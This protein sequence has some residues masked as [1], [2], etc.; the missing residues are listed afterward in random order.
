MQEAEN[1]L[2]TNWQGTIAVLIARVLVPL[3]L[4]L[5]AVLKLMDMSPAHLPA[6]MIK[7]CGA[8]GIDLMFV[9]RFTIAAELIVAGVMVLLPPLARWVG[10]A[11]LLTFVPV[12]IGD[13]MMGA[14]SCGCFGA[15][16]VSPWVTFV[17]DVTFLFG[18]VFLGRRE[19]RLTLTSS[20]PTS[21]VLIAGLW[22]LLCV[23]VAFGS[24]T[25]A[26]A[27]DDD[28]A[29]GPGVI[30]ETT[31]PQ[32]PA[33]GYYMPQYDQWIGQY[34]VDLDLASW[35]SNL[36]EDIDLGPQYVIFYRKDCEHCH[37]LMVLYFGGSL[38][39]P[40]TAIA[41]PERDGF[42][43]ENL[44]PFECP[45]CRMAELPA[46]IDWF[47]QTPV[48]VRLMNGVVE[49]AAEVDATSPECLD[50]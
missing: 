32:L 5:G 42:P 1:G 36:P 18:L 47:L 6:A 7:W 50:W 29:D 48:L 41:V 34:F 25:P 46:G 39:Q 31:T 22:S 33:D 45:E 40:T 49:C 21:R 8:L 23:V 27:V 11:M 12:L 15:V 30:G 4:A 16:K 24:G 14:S 43:T 9:L 10:V 2:Q 13:L 26:P 35:T 37:E 20:L 28:G 19:P 44:Q 38:D 3:W 17:M